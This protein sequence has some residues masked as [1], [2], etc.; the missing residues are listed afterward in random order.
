MEI[1]D[2]QPN[3]GNIDL[4]LSIT[5]KGDIRTFEKF[6]K[7]G[8]VCTI[9]VKDDSGEIKL[10]LWN[11][12]T[13]RIDVNDKIHLKNGWCSEYK[14]EKQLS[15]GKFGQIEILEKATALAEKESSPSQKKED[16]P[17]PYPKEKKHSDS[18]LEEEPVKEE[19]I[20]E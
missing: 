8:Q 13:G 17:K 16:S 1:K 2:L 7:K 19:E 18:E 20:I 15:T 11:D 10:T 5:E 9:N 14:G 6:G 3:Q 4:V 12:D